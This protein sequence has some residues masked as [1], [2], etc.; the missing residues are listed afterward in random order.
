M[1]VA[2]I[3]TGSIAEDHAA[4][5]LALAAAGDRDLRLAAVAGREPAATEAFAHRFGA[6]RASIDLA[7]I[8]GDPAIDAVIVTTPTDL[9]A[10]HTAQALRAGKHTL[11]EI[12]LATS[13]AEADALL[14]LADAADRRLVVC[15][16]QRCFA[17]LREARRMIA[18]GEIAVHAI[19]SRYLF[20]RRDRVNWKGRTRSWTDNLLWHHGGHAIDATLWLLGVESADGLMVASQIAPPD[21]V[22][23]IPMDIG[24]VIRT[25]AGQIAT[26]AL[27]YHAM[28]PQHDYLMI[29]E[30]T[31]IQFIANELRSPA[32]VLVPATGPDP[33]TDALPRQNAEFF[34]AIRE[35]REP[36]ISARAIRPAMAVLEEVG[37]GALSF[38]L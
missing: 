21:R 31:S 5:I 36:A 19:V 6:A 33:L 22:T 8:L 35:H 2:I 30:A 15:H 9:H 13:L 38:E 29:G 12:P 27:S 37:R 20:N 14:A 17:P 25:P 11:C 16:T 24:V 4:A 28:L 26:V 23:G 10:A 7:A 34:A 32:G 1:N 18:D 3:G